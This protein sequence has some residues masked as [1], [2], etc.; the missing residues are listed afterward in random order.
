[1]KIGDA[2]FLKAVGNNARYRKETHIVEYKVGKVGRKYLEVHPEG[3]VNNSVKF[4]METKRQHTNFQPDWELYF[5][6]QEI[7]DEEEFTR[8]NRNIKKKFDTYS[9]VDLTLDQLR[10]ISQII[11]E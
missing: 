6:M 9:K 3:Y 10:R 4:N 7:L 1:M 11:N 5:S 2:V 8:L